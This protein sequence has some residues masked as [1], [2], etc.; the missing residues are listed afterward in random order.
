MKTKYF[1]IHI[2]PP[3]YS[4]FVFQT[5]FRVSK[6]S[7]QR[8]VLHIKQTSAQTDRRKIDLSNIS[9]QLNVTSILCEKR[10]FTFCSYL[11]RGGLYCICQRSKSVKKKR[12]SRPNKLF[13][14]ITFLYA[15]AFPS[16]Q[17]VLS[18]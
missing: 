11:T 14:V 12:R 7:Y 2:S 15:L 3:I 10:T 4:G 17:G 16:T 13:P 8:H 18:K 5:Q 6:S 9:S 1:P